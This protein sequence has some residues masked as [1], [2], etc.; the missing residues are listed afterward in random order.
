MSS[1]IRSVPPQIP[2]YTP[3]AAL[4]TG[5]FAEVFLY[6]Q[7]MPE[8]EV[9]VK[10]LGERL[11]GADSRQQ[12][13]TEANLMARLSTH[14]YIVTIYTADVTADGRPFLVMEYCSGS[15]LARRVKREPLSVAEVLRTGIRMA[16][17]VETAHRA[18][19]LHRDIKPANILV[20]DFGAPALTDFGI[21]AAV[22]DTTG[23]EGLSVPWAPP[24]VLEDP[25]RSTV[26]SDVYSLGATVWHLLAGRS[27]FAV[28]GG[29]NGVPD[30][31]HRIT[32]EPVPRT[33]REDVP[34]RLERVLARAMAKDPAQRHATALDLARDLQAVENAEGYA[35]TPV[36]VRADTRG[37]RPAPSAPVRPAA[38]P[39]SPA[40]PDLVPTTGPTRP[41]VAAPAP[42]PVPQPVPQPMPPP[43][44]VPPPQAEERTAARPG[45]G[46]PPPVDDTQ[47]RPAAPAP[48]EP[49]PAAPRR[50]RLPVVLAVVA[51]LLVL[52]GV[53]TWLV[54][55]DPDRPTPPQPTTA[56][57]ATQEGVPLA[58]VPAP[59]G[60]AG[61]RQADGS[62]LFTWQT[63]DPAEGD[64]WVVR[65]TEPG[66]PAGAQL[67][68][69][70][71]FT[72]TGVPAG[73]Q[74][75]VAVQVRR[76]DGTL[77]R[78]PAEACAG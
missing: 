1:A 21:S 15:D 4:G 63:P 26:Q 27:P 16:G 25:A 2:G 42:A 36:D 19:I 10:V 62:L 66:A 17:A 11:T 73:A 64:S 75:C 45:A 29:P 51:V 12:F 52:G 20:T 77:S 48:E 53:V 30:L 67:V 8:R 22:H 58:V 71:A 55:G 31:V 74:A 47:V 9:A 69:E 3:E 68:G 70:P 41:P 34:S 7:A 76:A 23:I 14:P 35:E 49:E 43:A 32:S 44:P 65:R 50:G 59:T 40:D 46:T 6:R 5:G 33:G 24:E 56:S 57:P 28:P 54:T 72:V 39:P 37:G 38:S 78:E 13:F 61:A 18:G 60:L